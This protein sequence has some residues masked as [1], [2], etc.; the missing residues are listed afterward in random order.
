MNA[1]PLGPAVALAAAARR[2][3]PTFA[4]RLALRADQISAALAD[5]LYLVAWD[6]EQLIGAMQARLAAMATRAATAVPRG[7]DTK[8]GARIVERRVQP[9]EAIELAW[10][11]LF[12]GRRVQLSAEPGACSATTALVADMA[13]LLPA[14]AVAIAGREPVSGEPPEAAA[15]PLRGVTPA[16]ARI[17]WVD[18][19]AD[20]ELA[21]YSLARTCLRRSGVDP[22][23]VRIACVAGPTDLLKRHLVRLWVGAQ[24]GPAS[25]PGSF[26]GPVDEATR[27]AFV[28][29][30]AAWLADER[31]ELWCAGGVLEH[32]GASAP[33][34]APAAFAVDWPPPTLPM[35]GPM[36]CIVRCTEAQGHETIRAAA[37]GGAA[38]VQI[39]GRPLA[40][41]GELR[42]IRGAVLVE[43]LPPGLPEPRPV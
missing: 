40:D 33:F 34:V 25:D 26:A 38:V 27:D 23:A 35:A 6:R 10:E 16:V 15:W 17:A 42:H 1:P 20:R 18:A 21:A 36:C 11:C 8:I 4:E 37:S 30:Q 12:A 5:E 7:A 9:L 19:T 3:F 13:S 2:V 14:G 29:A 39:G 31:V 41:I 28:V 43:R 32:A 24:L 22:R